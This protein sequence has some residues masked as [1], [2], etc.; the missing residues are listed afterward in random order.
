MKRVVGDDTIKRRFATSSVPVD[1]TWIARA[2][3]RIRNA[4]PTERRILDWDLADRV[5]PR[6]DAKVRFQRES[7]DLRGAAPLF[8]APR[9]RKLRSRPT[10]GKPSLSVEN[11]AG[12][13]AQGIS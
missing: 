9:S 7:F 5:F 4:L 3:T 12:L 1:A 6:T 2:A 8:G 10:P 13:V 11:S